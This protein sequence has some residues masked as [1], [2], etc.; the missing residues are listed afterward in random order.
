MKI[1]LIALALLIAT[2]T[3]AQDMKSLHAFVGTYKCTGMAFAS[4]MGPEHPTTATVTVKPVLGGKWLETRYTENKTAKNPM[5]FAI[6]TYW[7]WDEGQKKFVSTGVDSMGGH[8]TQTSSG[9]SGETLVFEGSMPM[10]P[11]TANFKDTFTI[12]GKT[13][14]HAGAMQDKSGG[15]KKMDE[16]TCKK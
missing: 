2:S 15:W 12:K 3:F 9:M 4:E 11:M 6:V 5:P 7:G 13:A 16:E 1:R 8:G 10:G 14:T